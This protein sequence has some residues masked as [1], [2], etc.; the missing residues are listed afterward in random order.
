MLINHDFT[1]TSEL[2]GTTVERT[3]PTLARVTLMGYSL[4]SATLGEAARQ[5]CN[6]AEAHVPT[7]VNFVNAH[8]INTD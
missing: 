7:T 1:P 4:L 2:S 5:I 3:F 6:R 8:C